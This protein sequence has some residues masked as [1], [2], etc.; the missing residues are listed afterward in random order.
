MLTK[1]DTFTSEQAAEDEIAVMLHEDPDNFAHI[2]DRYQSEDADE[3]VLM[4]TLLQP[5]MLVTA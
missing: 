3:P 1:V 5:V 2:P 4:K